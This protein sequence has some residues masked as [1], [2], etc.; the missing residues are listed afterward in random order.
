MWTVRV[1]I[2]EKDMP[3]VRDEYRLSPKTLEPP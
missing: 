2:S 1:F 3:Q